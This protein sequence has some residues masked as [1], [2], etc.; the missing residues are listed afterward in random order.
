MYLYYFLSAFGPGMQPYLWWK[1]SAR[2]RHLDS[3]A[4]TGTELKYDRSRYLTRLQMAQFVCVF[5]HALLPLMF[6]CGYPKIVAQVMCLNAAAFF[7]LFANFYFCA[8][9]KQKKKSM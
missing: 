8:Y 5:I 3:P 7:T 9:I 1:R 2:L 6:D 4:S